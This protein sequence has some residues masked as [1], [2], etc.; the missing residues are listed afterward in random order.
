MR[1]FLRLT[2]DVNERLRKLMRY[3]GELSRYIDDALTN[4]NLV[5]VDL[6]PIVDSRDVPGMTAVISGRANAS[7]RAA[8]RQRG[9]SITTL[10]NSAI[11]YWLRGKD[12]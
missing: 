2:T 4:T 12:I 1:L 5:T 11:H 6:L 10:A 7:L 3:H 8:A 9:C